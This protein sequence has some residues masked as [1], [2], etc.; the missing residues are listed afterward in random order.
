MEQLINRLLAKYDALIEE[1]KVINEG[2][3]GLV[4]EA[5]KNPDAPGVREWAR[6]ARENLRRLQIAKA[7]R[8]SLRENYL[9]K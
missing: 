4:D 2:N 6:F 8:D 1:L 3:K 5:N 9:K 7:E